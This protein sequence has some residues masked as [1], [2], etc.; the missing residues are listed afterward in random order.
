MIFDFQGKKQPRREES[1][2]A[3]EAS[4][5]EVLTI[6]GL[7]PTSYSEV[8]LPILLFAFMFCIEMFCSFL[9]SGSWAAKREGTKASWIEWGRCVAESEGEDRR[10]EE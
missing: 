8:Q 7:M 6:L 2:K 1:L 5:R 10:K 4:V 9:L 3:L